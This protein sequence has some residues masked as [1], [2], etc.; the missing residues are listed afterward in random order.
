MVKRIVFWGATGHAKVLRELT[1]DL[2]Y[3]LVAV[4]DNNPRV[5][6]P[7]ADVDVHYGIDGFREWKAN[8]ENLETFC[9]VAIGGARG[10]DRVDILD[11]LKQNGIK[12][13]AAIHP[14]AFVARSTALSDGC[15]VLASATVCSHAVLGEAS[16]V[17]TASSVD[18]ES[19]LGRGVHIA[20]GATLAGCV[21][22][23]DYSFIGAGAV[24]LPTVNIGS[25][26]IVG[27]GAVVTRDI[28]DGKV[29]FGNP[30]KIRRENVFPK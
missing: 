20:P 12:P 30:A 2:G 18:H 29:A 28:A 11:F 13:I 21:R 10:R 8:N 19:V 24:V 25:N 15:Q 14:T 9:L 7:F 23:G 4:F 3:T 27:A 16:I 22:V 17:N 6:P 26:V 5:P 1:D